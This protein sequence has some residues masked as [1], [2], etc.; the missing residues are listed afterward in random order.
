MAFPGYIEIPHQQLAVAGL[1]FTGQGDLCRCF[2][3]DG[4]LKDWSTG[5]DP[6]R[7]HAT[8]FRNCD[9]INQLKGQDYVK[10]LQQTRQNNQPAGAAGGASQS[11]LEP[12]TSSLLPMDRLHISSSDDSRSTVSQITGMGYS[13]RDVE[14]A[15][16][17]LERKGRYSSC[18]ENVRLKLDESLLLTLLIW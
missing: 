6:C 16:A 10:A 3:C 1:Y 14:A 8:Y 18:R 13:K 12:E 11:M 17:K 9:Y 5:D 7:E 2:T 4:G 15:K